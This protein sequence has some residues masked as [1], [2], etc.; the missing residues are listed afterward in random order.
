MLN[1]WQD[2]PLLGHAKTPIL[3][4]Q[5]LIAFVNWKGGNEPIGGDDSTCESVAN[6]A[7]DKAFS[8]NPYVGVFLSYLPIFVEEIDPSSAAEA[9][10]VT[11]MIHTLSKSTSSVGSIEKET[12]KKKKDVD[13]GAAEETQPSGLFEG[14]VE[15][16]LSYASV[17]AGC[18]M[19]FIEQGIDIWVK[20]R[21]CGG[22]NGNEMEW[23]P[24][25][26]SKEGRRFLS[27]FVRATEIAEAAEVD[28]NNV[29][30]VD[31]EDLGE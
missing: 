30:D 13:S 5:A 21:F 8:A 9:S 1:Q 7:L 15:E 27:M 6:A 31:V 25:F 19:D 10:K 24:R 22:P 18:W 23:P 3:F 28:E 29:E 17:A 26:C 12:K 16:A 20:E 11:P 14:S 4:S 2:E